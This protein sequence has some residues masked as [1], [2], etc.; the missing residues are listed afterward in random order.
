M[1]DDR[2]TVGVAPG[3]WVALRMIAVGMGVF[4]AVALLHAVT[5]MEVRDKSDGHMLTFVEKLR[6]TIILALTGAGLWWSG[7][8][9]RRFGDDRA[10]DR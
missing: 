4:S 9:L 6:V 3:A 8:R 7:G 1:K 10:D 2:V 5:G